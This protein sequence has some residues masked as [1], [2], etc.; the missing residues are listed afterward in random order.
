MGS[1]SGLIPLRVIHP[2]FVM[3]RPHYVFAL[4]L[5][6]STTRLSAQPGELPFTQINFQTLNDFRPASSNWK[7]AADVFFNLNKAN[8]STT[9]SGTGIVVHRL[10][11]PEVTDHLFTK[12][13]HGDIALDLEFMLDKG[14]AAGIALQGRYTIL[15]TDS[16]GCSAPSPANCGAIAGRWDESRPTGRKLFES[17]SPTQNVTKAPGLWQQLS[18]VFRAPRF[19]QSGQKIANAR[20]V[21][22]VLNGVTVQTN[23]ELTGPTQRAAFADEKPTGPLVILGDGNGAALRNVR[24]KAYGTEP[25]TLTNM[26]L[27]AYSG[28]FA[29]VADFNSLTP[30]HQLPLDV[31]AH[32]APGNRDKFGGIITGTLHIPRSGRYL[33]NLNTNW[34]PADTDPNRPN[35]AAE[36]TIDGKPALL[37]TGKQGGT[38]SALLDLNAGDLPLVLAYYK[39][40]GLWYARSNDIQLSVEGP[41]VPYTLLN[42]VIRV[43]D[44][45]GQISLLAKNEPVMQRGFVQHQ[46]RK[47][48][49]TISVGEPCNA[50][51]T[52]DLQKGEFL[53]L[54]RG[55]FLETT[56]MWYGRG[57]TQLSVPLGSVIELVGKPSLAF[58]TD[59]TT[60]WPDSNATYTNLGY[61]IDK[62]GRPVFKYTLGSA[63]V[64]ESFAAEDSGRQLTHSFTIT[65][66][67]NTPVNLWC[68]AAEG[69]AISLLTNGLYAINDNQYFIRLPSGQKPLIRIT[70]QNRQEMLLPVN[71]GSITYSIVW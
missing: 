29:S 70:A 39:N 43:E 10:T 38:A 36:L 53:Q 24:Y 40:F 14:V 13:E 44:P 18:V 63:S 22:V 34:I 4:F 20:L 27:A 60:T 8:N 28:K 33:L 19:N 11:A 1:R 26:N 49:H 42:P 15:L 57:E 21:R 46:G 31:L 69:S 68:R 30:T 12:M 52:V 41:G 25:V 32:L 66:P 50:N 2:S 61:D 58:L 59:Q 67:S 55:D 62:T 17:H 51:Y 5:L 37:I 35:G 47:H 3:F 65:Q 45:V 7:L 6:L 48:T 71:A 9:K 23:V 16:W 54:W 56:P 64:R